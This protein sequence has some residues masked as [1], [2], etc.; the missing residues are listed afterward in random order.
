MKVS[1]Y[2]DFLES[3]TP[4]ELDCVLNYYA[5]V[6]VD[7]RSKDFELQFGPKFT[8]EYTVY[9]KLNT[10]QEGERFIA[11]D[12]IFHHNTGNVNVEGVQVIDYAGEEELQL[13]RKAEELML[14]DVQEPD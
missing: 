6:A 2:S 12:V 1:T 8:V 13:V 3:I 5:Q 7:D 4:D 9:M 14:E 11:I 10:E